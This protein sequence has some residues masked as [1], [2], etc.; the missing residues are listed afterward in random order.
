MTKYRKK[1][2]EVAL[3]LEAINEASA[4]EKMPGIGPHP[5]GLH[6]WWARRPLAAA[7]A[8][9]FSQIVDDP[10]SD[11]DLAAYKGEE[12]EQAVASARAK[13]HELIRELVKWESTNNEEVLNRARA[14]IARSFALDKLD[15]GEMAKDSP[16][17]D[18]PPKTPRGFG[19]DSK[20]VLWDLRR[21]A[22]KPEAVRHFLA[23]HSP[24][25]HDPFAGGGALPLEAQRLGLNSYASDLNP[26][27]V[28][29]NKAMIE[30][31]PKFAGLPSVNPDAR[32]RAGKSAAL[33]G[34][35][36][37][38][39]LAEDVRFYGKWMR[40]EA[41]KRIGHLYPKIEVTKEMVEGNE[42]VPARPDLKQYQGR[43]LTVIAWL[44]ARTVKSPNPA[45]SHVHVP[46]V[47][48]FW[49][50]S[51]EGKEVY[52]EPIINREKPHSDAAKPGS[53]RFSIQVGTPRNPDA[54]KQGTKLSRGANFRCLISGAPIA[55]EHIY[56][57]AL[58]GR[59]GTRL[60]A[61]V[62]GG[63]R[64]RVYL[65]PT[66]EHE[67]IALKAVPTWIPDLTMPEN[68]RW[69]SPPL[70]GLKRYG[71]L[72][73]SR[74]L[75]AL[76]TLSTLVQEARERIKQDAAT[77]GFPDDNRPF[78]D[79]GRGTQAY[80]D[81]VAV[82]LAFA[83]DRCVDFSNTCTRWVAGNQKVMNLFGKQAIGMTW[84]FPE[85]GLLNDTV[86]G[87]VPAA[88][89]I[90]DCIGKL[91][92][93]GFGE[94]RQAD[95]TT[96]EL[97]KR[98]SV[99]TDP[100]Y[101]DNIGYADLSDFFY[102]WLRRSLQP[103]FPDLFATLAV[104]KAQE[105][106]ATPYR[107]GSKDKAER[108]FLEGMTLAM[109]QLAEQAYQGSPTTIYYAF[110][111]AETD[112][113]SGT[114]STGWETFLD[115]VINA[116]L[117][118][119][120]TW[121]L[122][123]EQE[124]RMVGMGTNALASSIILV[125]RPRPD[126]A[127]STTRGAFDRT[128]KAELPEALRQM[129][130][131]N[132]APVDLPQSCIG[133]GMAI[134]TRYKSVLNQ[135]DSPMKVRQALQLINE[136]IDNFFNEQEADYDPETRFALTW[137]DQHGFNDGPFGDAD[138]LA[139][140]RNVSVK[141]VEDAG[142]L[143]QGQSKARLLRRDELPKD[144]DPAQDNRAVAWEFTQHLVRQLEEHGETGAAELA[145]KLTAHQRT[146]ARE[147]AYRLYTTCE[148]KKNAGEAKAYNSLITSWPEIER[149]A[150]LE[151]KPAKGEA[152]DLFK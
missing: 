74:Q 135:D 57:E 65:A 18:A 13:L 8:V 19:D 130:T 146:L 103:V 125:C 122:R 72:F 149:L 118:I 133:P 111:Q 106:V 21:R 101:Y 5:R 84:D 108:F 31:P 90:A 7:R 3:P 45:Y 63:N 33:S 77:A 102:I 116:G 75:V 110:K 6:L 78:S 27:A 144:W 112:S 113:A 23:H 145:T 97:S 46:L 114:S 134:F 86:G 43:K 53:Y 64:G 152:K 50:S 22:A 32:K 141:G 70:Y 105:L 98:K 104:P 62:A 138:N 73:T 20:T 95:A 59:M 54:V 94:A 120:G 147:L 143:K 117:S 148:R 82:Y 16:F 83:V 42:S 89:F 37:A 1:L 2:I 69:F 44:W 39:G 150:A 137:F 48:T 38:Q 67:A 55:P 100:P 52:V 99:S 17:F 127:V 40:D 71:D 85:A 151:A 119:S 79:S 88:N 60:M 76:T 129:Q 9:I 91:P 132:I 107:H 4:Y 93:A 121:P 96:N 68:P 92:Q 136:A 36:G 115:A 126:S 49:L 29:I 123:S 10:S 109:H 47:S 61:I 28:L 81:A 56:S 66:S 24:G 15:S 142:I 87:V 124:Y 14:E 25:F 140:A 41:E 30:I 80:A 12:R 139:R 51:K 26:V 34:Y 35:K 58:A 128:L 11:P 131:A